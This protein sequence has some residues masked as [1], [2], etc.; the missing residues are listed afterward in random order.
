MNAD[1]IIIVTIV[2]FSRETRG[3]IRVHHLPRIVTGTATVIVEGIMTENAAGI[4][5]VVAGLRN[6][7]KTDVMTDYRCINEK[8][9]AITACSYHLEV[10]R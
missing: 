8:E 4:M 3:C 10:L 7:K 1:V 5:T 2:A 6:W 9:Q